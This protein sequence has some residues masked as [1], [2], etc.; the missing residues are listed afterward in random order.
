METNMEP[1]W[2]Q[3]ADNNDTNIIRQYQLLLGKIEEK[4]QCLRRL[5]GDNMETWWR[6]NG[7]TNGDKPWR[8]TWRQQW[9]LMETK[10]TK[11]RQNVHFY[12]VKLRKV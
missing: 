7:N 3:K 4:P 6:P 2:R 8:Q 10:E 11:W 1:K 12:L 5:F 9:R